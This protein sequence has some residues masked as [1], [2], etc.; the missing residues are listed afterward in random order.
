V[1]VELQRNDICRLDRREPPGEPP[2]ENILNTTKKQLSGRV[3]HASL[4]LANKFAPMVCEHI[5]VELHLLYTALLVLVCRII[6]VCACV[7]VCVFVS[8]GM[9]SRYGHSRVHFMATVCTSKST[10]V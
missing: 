9:R 7:R 6:Q 2:G 3:S 4:T 10:L 5:R 8:Y 1:R